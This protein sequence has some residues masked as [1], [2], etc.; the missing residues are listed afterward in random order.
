MY[1]YMYSTT[2]QLTGTLNCGRTDEPRVYSYQDNLLL[3]HLISLKKRYS[4]ALVFKF[5]NR[6]LNIY[7]QHERYVKAAEYKTKYI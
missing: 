3:Y 2:R 7:S 6:R 5:F 1:M 4:M